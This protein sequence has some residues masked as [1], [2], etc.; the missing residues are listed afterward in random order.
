MREHLSVQFF[1]DLLPEFMDC[2]EVNI[3][4]IPARQ[5]DKMVVMF[6]VPAKKIVKLPVRMGNL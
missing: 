1:L 4:H 6:I 5:A 2:T 3:I